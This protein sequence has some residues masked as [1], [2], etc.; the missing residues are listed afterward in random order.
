MITEQKVSKRL[1]GV[2][3]EC[4]VEGGYVPIAI[5]W[6]DQK[7]YPINVTWHEHRRDCY[8]DITPE[9]WTFTIGKHLR[10]L[11]L[12]DNGSWYVLHDPANDKAPEQGYIP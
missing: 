3:V 1:V 7:I 10:T 5:K 2:I 4:K 11:V 6:Y 12:D 9:S 8:G